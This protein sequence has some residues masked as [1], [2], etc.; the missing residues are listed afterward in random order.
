MQKADAKVLRLKARWERRGASI[1]LVFSIIAITLGTSY[2]VMRAQ[3]YTTRLQQN[4]NRRALAR[5]DAMVGLSVGMRKMSE[6]AWTGVG[7]TIT[8]N[9]SA[10]DSYQ[11]SFTTGDSKLTTSSTN[12]SDYPYRVTVQ[13]IGT[14]IDPNNV[15]SHATYQVTAV[16]RLVPRQLATQPTN[17]AAMQNYTVYQ[18]DSKPFSIDPPCQIT[19]P[20]Y[21]QGAVS[22]G[23]DYKWTNTIESQYLG[24]LN[25]MRTHGYSDYRPLTGAVSLPL[26]STD[27]NTQNLLSGQLGLSLGNVTIGSAVALPTPNNLATYRI[28]PGGKSYNVGAVSTSLSNVALSSDP[29]TNPLGIFFNSNS[30]G[31]G[32]GV[33]VTGTLISGGDINFTGSGASFL[34]LSLPAIS[35]TSTPVRLPAVV[36]KS[37]IY[38]SASGQGSINGVMIAGSQFLIDVGPQANITSLVGRVITGTFTISY[39]NEWNVGN[40]IWQSNYSGWKTQSLIKYLPDWYFLFAAMNYVPGC[41]LKTDSTTVNNHWLDLTTLPV[42]AVYASDGGLRW[43]LVDWRDNQ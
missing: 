37:K 7:T 30:I 42:Y 22:L 26:S 20:L 24:D 27:S 29:I 2:A 21:L 3:F 9:L 17:W 8:G 4:G 35:P 28:Y 39:R 41:T 25:A 34:P 10:Q 1:T 38:F 23:V 43:E 13:S 6:S 15:Q 19:G 18:T 16:L 12:Y 11:V 14:S 5:Q 36:A 31:I 32:N 40:G 33:S